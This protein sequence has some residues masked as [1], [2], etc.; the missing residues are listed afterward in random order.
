MRK[1]WPRVRASPAM[2]ALAQPIAEN[3]QLGS[4]TQIG[5]AAFQQSNGLPVTG[6]LD[7]QTR[8]QM[9]AWLATIGIHADAGLP[10][11]GQPPAAHPPHG[12]PH[13]APGAQPAT[14]PDGDGPMPIASVAPPLLSV[15][16]KPPTPFWQATPE[17][18]P[19][20]ICAPAGK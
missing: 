17:I 15:W 10:P 1:T 16:W 6:Q 8:S 19:R 14:A 11:P 2:I 4:D 13:P 3:D 20:L 7:D 5:L 18:P 12:H 9:V